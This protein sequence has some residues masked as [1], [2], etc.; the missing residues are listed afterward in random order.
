MKKLLLLFVISSFSI[1]TYAQCSQNAGIDYALGSSSG[2]SPNYLLGSAI[3]LSSTF[4]LTEMG[5][6]SI[7]S[8]QNFKVAVYDDAAGNPGNLLTEGAGTAVVGTNI[9]DVP[10]VVLP[11]GTYYYMAIFETSASIS[12]TTTTSATVWY[13]SLP[14]SS[15]LPS[16]FGTP[17]TYTGQDFSYYFIGSIPSATGT[18]VQTACNSFTWI[19]GLTYTSSNN[20]A[21][22]NIVGGAANGCDSLVTLDLTI[23]SV[24]DVT[25]STSGATITANNSSATY[26]WL[27]C[28]NAFAVI[29]G[30]TSSSFTAS[31]N[32]NYA[33]A[34]T[35]N[36]CVDTS[37]CVN[38][39]FTG[40]SNENFGQEFIV[41][42]NPTNG[43]FTIDLGENYS[44]VNTTI[45]DLTGRLI[46]SSSIGNAS[47]L[48]FEINEPA[49]IYILKI[50]AGEKTSVVRLI[51][52]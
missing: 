37:A 17:L 9:I 7:N 2:H 49:G 38:I 6:I 3:T 51:K 10:D 46:L 15:A 26:Q 28:G 4:N 41:Y 42:P 32:G 1:F 16:S 12:F 35:E 19:D 29:T 45:T 14:F 39:D 30:A 24:S 23:N 13:I 20:T 36:G 27:D 25:T 40:L 5:F 50:E 18:D 31:T 21:T 8:G 11:A 34:I 22:Y 43:N 47:I 44:I 52:E 33:V 48:N